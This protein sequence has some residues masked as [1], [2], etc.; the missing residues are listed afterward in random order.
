[1]LDYMLVSRPLLPAVRG[2]RVVTQVPW[3][4]HFGIERLRHWHAPAAEQEVL[5]ERS[6]RWS[7]GSVGRAAHEELL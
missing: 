7:L 6:L 4:T 1:M 3:E 2:A 5:R